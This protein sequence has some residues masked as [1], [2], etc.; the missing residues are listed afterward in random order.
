MKVVFWVSFYCR[1]PFDVQFTATPIVRFAI[2]L[3]LPGGIW[4]DDL[5][6]YYPALNA[7]RLWAVWDEL[8]FFWSC[9]IQGTL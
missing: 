4:D 5:S 1:F 7:T 3:A 2:H 6:S 8:L 9:A